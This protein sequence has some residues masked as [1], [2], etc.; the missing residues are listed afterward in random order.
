MSVKYLAWA[1]DASSFILLKSSN[2]DLATIEGVTLLG[3]VLT[4]MSLIV[5]ATPLSDEIK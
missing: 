3:S 5:G 2:N 4:L 1:A